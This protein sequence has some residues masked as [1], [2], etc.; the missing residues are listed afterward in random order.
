MKGGRSCR[1]KRSLMLCMAMAA[2]L[3]TAQSQ[4]WQPIGQIGGATQ[5]VA[6]QGHYG[7][8]GVGLRLVVLDVSDPAA[9]REVGV[10][11]PFPHFVEDIAVSGTLAYVAAGGAGLR[12]VDISDPTSP[13]EVGAWD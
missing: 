1:G 9:L 13:L 6:V 2:V 3:A 7:Y 11:Q 4:N 5:A 10:T 8:L 12:V